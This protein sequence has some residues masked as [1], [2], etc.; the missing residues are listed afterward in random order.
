MTDR[1]V[2]EL[3]NCTSVSLLF[4]LASVHPHP[5]P[6]FHILFFLSLQPNQILGNGG[7]KDSGTCLLSACQGTIAP[8]VSRPPARPPSVSGG[9]FPAPWPRRLDCEEHC[10]GPGSHMSSPGSCGPSGRSWRRKGRL[11]PCRR[12]VPGTLKPW[13]CYSGFSSGEDGGNLVPDAPSGA[14]ISRH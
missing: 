1:H 14:G 13:G 12:H 6:R 5:P 3:S 2:P 7:W 9:G 10:P 4:L 8:L 11:H